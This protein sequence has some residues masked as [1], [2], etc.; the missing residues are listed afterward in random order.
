MDQNLDAKLTI[1]ALA[2]GLDLRRSPSRWRLEW[3]ADRLERG[4]RLDEDAAGLVTVTALCWNHGEEAPLR[5][6]T[7]AVSVGPEALARDL[8]GILERGL[9]AANAL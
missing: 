2:N 1:F 4:I 6:E 9:E 7:C 8:S 5:E 3:H